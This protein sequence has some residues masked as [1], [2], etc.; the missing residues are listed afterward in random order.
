MAIQKRQP[1][2]SKAVNTADVDAALGLNEPQPAAQPQ[3]QPV[4]ETEDAMLASLAEAEKAAFAAGVKA[5]A[6]MADATSGLYGKVE[7]KLDAL[8][9]NRDEQLS[10]QIAERVFAVEN[11]TLGKSFGMLMEYTASFNPYRG[12]KLEGLQSQPVDIA[13]LMAGK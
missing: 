6:T 1:E 4:A 7:S 12:T 10:T 5:A 2:T 8:R 9:T 13:A 11:Q 3:T